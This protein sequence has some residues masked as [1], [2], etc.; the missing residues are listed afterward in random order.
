MDTTITAIATPSGRGGIG[1]IRISGI[2]ALG[3]A[4][5][6]FVYPDKTPPRF[7]KPR[8]IHYGYIIDK[9]SKYIDEVLLFYMNGPQSYTAEDVVE[10]QSH[11][12]PIVLRKILDLILKCGAELAEPG[13]FTKR[14]YLNGRIDLTQA[15]AVIDIINARTS[16]SLDMAVS[17]VSGQLKDQLNEIINVLSD[18]R[19]RIEAIIDFPDDVG[20]ILDQRQMVDRLQTLVYNPLRKL[21]QNFDDSNIFR[22]GIK[23]VIAGPPNSGKSSL[24]NALLNK[25]KS[26]VTPVPG[27]TRDLIDDL[28]NIEGIPFEITDT[29][30][31]QDTQDQVEQLGILRT[32]DRMKLSDLIILM[33]D[34]SQSL[35][36]K[37]QKSLIDI[38]NEYRQIKKIVVVENKIDLHSSHG[39]LF[40]KIKPDIRL[41]V[42]EKIGL[43]ELKKKIC[44]AVLDELPENRSSI[45]PN[46][47]H[48]Q[49]IESALQL[50]EQIIDG[51]KGDRG[52]ELI[53]ID[54]NECINCLGEIIGSFVH[55]DILDRI[56]H[57]FCIGK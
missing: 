46:V 16:T 25:E 50:Y 3:I 7:I 15:E 38:Y 17:Q 44:E 18:D 19:A 11:S 6:I 5:K 51:L 1:I 29:A 26:I 36:E 4:I 48:I 23:I 27:T 22:D 32:F 49:L 57:S 54:L 9:N 12:S 14:A 34:G 30:G 24:L 47:R 21:K 39:A 43:D 2:D 53:A 55:D 37:E 40:N 35:N 20:D 42:L 45:V 52:C 31:I 8:H 13:E 41:S 33:F 10:I 28:I 56:F